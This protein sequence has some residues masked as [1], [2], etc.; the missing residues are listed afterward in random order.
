MKKY[1]AIIKSVVTEKSSR[2]QENNQYTFLVDRKAN[3]TLIKQA[4]ETMFGEKV[5]NIQTN[6]MAKKKR[7]AGRNVMVKRTNL[8]K[9]IVTFKGKKA[10]DPNKIEFSKK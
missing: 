5:E 2:Q 1:T 8:K 7:M 9:A 10:I 4:L 3:K 6:I